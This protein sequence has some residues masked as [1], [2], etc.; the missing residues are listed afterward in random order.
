[1]SIRACTAVK[2]LPELRQIVRDM[3]ETAKPCRVPQEASE[4]KILSYIKYRTSNI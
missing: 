3:T 1:M 2:F 4:I